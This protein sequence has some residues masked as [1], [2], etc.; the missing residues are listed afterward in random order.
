MLD[1]KLICS[2]ENKNGLDTQTADSPPGPASS[3]DLPFL[4]AVAVNVYNGL[5]LGAYI[6]PNS[7]IGIGTAAPVHGGAAFF[8]YIVAFHKDIVSYR[9]RKTSIFTYIS[10]FIILLQYIWT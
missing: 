8:A 5:A 3:L 6:Y 9:C 10:F 7:D 2:K 1:V 4:V